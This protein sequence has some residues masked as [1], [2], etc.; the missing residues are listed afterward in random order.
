MYK[1]TLDPKA[2]SLQGDKPQT[3]G[4]GAS[5]V[6]KICNAFLFALRTRAATNLQNIISAHVCKN[7]PDLEEGLLEVAK[8]QSKGE[9]NLVDEITG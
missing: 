4:K 3:L 2:S 7:P 1:D 8:L 6:N 9:S 5:K